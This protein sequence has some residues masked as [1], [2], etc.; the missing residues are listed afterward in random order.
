MGPLFTQDAVWDGGERFGRYEGNDAIC[1]F[2][3][4]VAAD[5]WALHY[6]IAPI[7]EVADD[8]ETATGSWYLLEPCTVRRRATG[9]GRWWITGRYADRYRR[10]QEGWKFS[11]L[12]VRLPDRSARL[13]EG[14]VR[15]RSGT[16]RGTRAAQTRHRGAQATRRASRASRSSRRRRSSSGP[17]ETRSSGPRRPRR[18]APAEFPLVEAVRDP[19]RPPEP[20]RTRTTRSSAGAGSEPRA[21]TASSPA[22]ASR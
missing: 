7:I 4:D 9:P 11:E 12:V 17:G 3:A 1:G 5:H 16:S 8:L 22:S 6:M 2:F 18:T 15:D 20:A 10:E 13:D 21:R 19:G 14:W